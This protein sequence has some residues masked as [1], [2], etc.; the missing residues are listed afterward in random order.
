MPKI[1]DHLEDR[2]IAEAEKQLAC[3]G[4]GAVTIRSVA[5]ACAIGTG[6][7]Y[8]YFPS[9]DAMLAA[10]MLKDWQRHIEAIRETASN[11]ASPEQIAG[12]VYAELR[13]YARSHAL[14]FQDASALAGFAAV[15]HRYHALLRAQLAQPFLAFCE[16]D[17]AADFVA[18]ALLTWTMAGKEFDE[19]YNLLRRLFLKGEQTNVQL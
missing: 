1:I 6:T 2:I 19:I 4:Y 3:S 8:N 11:A 17:F 7:V 12:T 9:K 15:S 10:C 18:E 14:L 5:H 16:S 13:D